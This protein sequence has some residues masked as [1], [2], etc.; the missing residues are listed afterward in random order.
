MFSIN[1]KANDFIQK[2][3]LTSLVPLYDNVV[4]FYYNKCS[5]KK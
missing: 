4:Y 1:Q 5:V 3:A 2:L